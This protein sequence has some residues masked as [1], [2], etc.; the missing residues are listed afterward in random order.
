MQ[1]SFVLVLNSF[2]FFYLLRFWVSKNL[3]TCCVLCSCMNFA[4]HSMHSTFVFFSALKIMFRCL[5]HFFPLFRLDIAA[6]LLLASAF[7]LAPHA[8]RDRSNLV[9]SPLGLRSGPG[10]PPIRAKNEAL[11]GLSPLF[12]GALRVPPL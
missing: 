10:I 6:A 7:E 12:T 2:S 5:A 8:C 11:R 3:A 9:G 1:S 4:I